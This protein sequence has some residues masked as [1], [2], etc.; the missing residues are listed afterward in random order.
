MNALENSPNRPFSPGDRVRVSEQFFWARGSGG[1]ISK[2]PEAVMAVSEQRQDG[3]A[4]TE[5]SAL[6]SNTV[7]WVW[8]DEPQ[9]DADGDGPYK[10]GHI[11]ESALTLISSA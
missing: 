8:F 6:G 3:V 1:R 4:R 2:P 11:W 10:G 5:V 9:F 7:Y